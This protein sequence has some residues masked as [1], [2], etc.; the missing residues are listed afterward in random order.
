MHDSGL[1]HIS[2][3][4]DKFVRDPHDVVAVGD[5]VRVW[6]MDIDKERRR[7]SLT[8]IQPGAERP[9]RP[10]HGGRTKRPASA[11]ESA[12]SHGEGRDSKQP[13]RPSGERR[14][15]KPRGRGRHQHEPHRPSPRPRPAPRPLIPITDDMKAG[16]EPMRTFGDLM[17]FYQT[18]TVSP[19]DGQPPTDGEETPTPADDAAKNGTEFS[20]TTQP[21]PT[22][23]E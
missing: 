21:P 15:Q 5:I 8:M 16:K 14:P 17:Q 18:K 19:E 13:P 4:A 1:V 22:D 10:H 11:G 23:R 12:R 20:S 3:L 7:V 6:V 2:R 9:K